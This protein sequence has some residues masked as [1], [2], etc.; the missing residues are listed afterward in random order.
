MRSRLLPDM[1]MALGMVL[2]GLASPCLAGENAPT[3]ARK[4]NGSEIFA[5][6][7]PQEQLV[8][9]NGV[10]SFD[11]AGMGTGSMLYPA[12]SA[13]GLLAAIVTHGL[14]ESSM[15]R[16]Q[17]AKLQEAA[18][19]V[20]TSYAPVLDG[21]SI[22]ELVLESLEKPAFGANKRM[23]ERT[24]DPGNDWVV[25]TTPVFRITQDQRALIID[26]MIAVYAPSL[27]APV[28][29]NTV[30]VVSDAIRANDPTVFWTADSGTQLKR[31]CADLYRTSVQIALRSSEHQSSDMQNAF[32]T[33]GYVEGSTRKWERGRPIHEECHRVV[34]LTLRGTLMSVPSLQPVSGADST[35]QCD[36]IDGG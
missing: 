35:E 3:S 4:W 27:T 24:A 16:K 12:P 21:Y 32:R 29:E 5:L 8:A 15:K 33:I 23:L 2:T 25:E 14:V 1:C 34:L 30:E 6:R 19:Q 20:L 18:N 22:R 7:L 13:V 10:V 26:N 17:H 9:L 28:Y 36:D 11:N 31:E